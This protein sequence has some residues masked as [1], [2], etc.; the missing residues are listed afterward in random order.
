MENDEVTFSK[1]TNLPYS[2]I[3]QEDLGWIVFSD[4]AG[5]GWATG[6]WGGDRNRRR[7]E[8][9]DTTA[10]RNDANVGQEELNTL[11]LVH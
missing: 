4:G 1:C 11:G 9:N 2:G 10:Y 7:L 8:R 3:S 5:L 6:L